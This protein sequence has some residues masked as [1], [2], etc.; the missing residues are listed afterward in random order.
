[1]LE[2]SK[3]PWQHHGVYAFHLDSWVSVAVLLPCCL[4]SKAETG[5]GKTALLKLTPGHSIA[6]DVKKC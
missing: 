3:Q 6:V 5:E 4:S 2:Q 1:M